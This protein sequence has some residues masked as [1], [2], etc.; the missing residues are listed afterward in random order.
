MPTNLNEVLLVGWGNDA[1][2]TFLSHMLDLLVSPELP[3]RWAVEVSLSTAPPFAF[4]SIENPIFGTLRD[5]GRYTGANG[6]S[7]EFIVVA[8]HT[9]EDIE[10]WK[11]PA[12]VIRTA[13]IKRLIVV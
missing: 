11:V 2:D 3:T 13:D 5:R 1:D 6:D 8:P 12:H 4:G 10:D 9:E 7:V